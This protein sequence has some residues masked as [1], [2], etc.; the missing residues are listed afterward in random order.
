MTDQFIKD[1]QRGRK[2]EEFFLAILQR[3]YPRAYLMDGD[4]PF[5]DIFIPERRFRVEV[6]CDY[7][8]K[9]YKNLAIECES[10][11]EPSGIEVTTADFWAI[12]YFSNSN[13]A[14]LFGLIPTEE[15]KGLT[16]NCRIAKAGDGKTSR[17]YQLPV[18]KFERNPFLK[19]YP[20]N[21]E[22]TA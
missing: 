17:V 8:S 10:R 3:E 20:L 22:H 2:A 21:N 15:L 11:E 16:E 13:D 14:W 6:K 9:K 19:I 1:L 5:F 12:C 7:L 18:F 4:F